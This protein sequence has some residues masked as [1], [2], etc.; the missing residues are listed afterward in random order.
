MPTDSPSTPSQGR[1]EV[2]MG[3]IRLV[4]EC[5]DFP[6]HKHA[7]HVIRKVDRHPVTGKWRAEGWKTG[8][9]L[10][11]RHQIRRVLGSRVDIN[12]LFER[13][14][15]TRWR[16]DD[17]ADAFWTFFLRNV[18]GADAFPDVVNVKQELLVKKTNNTSSSTSPRGTEPYALNDEFFHRRGLTRDDFVNALARCVERPDETFPEWL[19]LAGWDDVCEG[20]RDPSEYELPPAPSRTISAPRRARSA[21]QVPDTINK[22]R[23]RCESLGPSASDAS[24][25]TDATCG[26]VRGAELKKMQKNAIGSLADDVDA[27]GDAHGTHTA[28]RTTHRRRRRPAPTELILPKIKEE[29]NDG[30]ESTTAR[31]DF[32]VAASTLAA[33][34]QLGDFNAVAAALRTLIAAAPN[35][36]PNVNDDDGSLSSLA[37]DVFAEY[38]RDLMTDDADDVTESVFDDEASVFE[39]DGVLS[40]RVRILE[41][42]NLES[43]G[44]E[45][46]D[47]IPEDAAPDLLE[48]LLAASL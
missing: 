27:R 17:I 23:K 45:R 35:V 44:I 41:A 26:H 43:A 1:R 31:A 21:V 33:A 14:E 34:T 6:I 3:L 39:E 9:Q 38:N 4:R 5:T 10:R 40:S 13:L 28:L 29:G 20:D 7:A 48:D 30:Y 12:R 25:A 37:S 47:S 16:G 11:F 8:E 32:V 24:E 15:P 42:P 36:A 18:H 2:A 22:K 19:R 46:L